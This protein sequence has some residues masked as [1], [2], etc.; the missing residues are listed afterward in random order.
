MKKKKPPVEKK[1]W[2]TIAAERGRA[3]ANTLSEQEREQLLE[4]A[5]QM[6]YG[7]PADARTT[8]PR[9]G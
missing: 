7:E 3:K 1:T 2:W 9:R 4:R 8:P 6:T 5:M